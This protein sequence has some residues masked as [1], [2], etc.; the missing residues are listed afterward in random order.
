MTD[1]SMQS[2]GRFQPSCWGEGV[3]LWTAGE[4]FQRQG[5]KISKLTVGLVSPGPAAVT[6]PK[7]VAWSAQDGAGWGRTAAVQ[8]RQPLA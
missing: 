6:R 5:G 8:G 2:K 7:M 4:A 3:V 1:T